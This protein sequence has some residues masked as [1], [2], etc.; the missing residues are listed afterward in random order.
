MRDF[1]RPVCVWRWSW[2]MIQTSPD[3]SP[4]RLAAA[5]REL[6]NSIFRLRA[7]AISIRYNNGCKMKL[8]LQTPLRRGS[9]SWEPGAASSRI[10]GQHSGCRVA[11]HS[12]HAFGSL[13]VSCPRNNMNYFDRNKVHAVSGTG[14]YRNVCCACHHR[15]SG[16]SVSDQV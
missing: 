14:H 7:S 2:D 15:A 11:P 16:S 6:R 13:L 8:Q 10:R 5:V 1:P 12:P 9:R 4:M 3:G